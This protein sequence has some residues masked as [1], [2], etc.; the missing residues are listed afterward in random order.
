MAC[1][2]LGTQMPAAKIAAAILRDQFVT[3]I[4]GSPQQVQCDAKMAAVYATDTLVTGCIECNDFPRKRFAFFTP[5]R[6]E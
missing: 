3:F 2:M 1:A 6:T 5:P 4:S